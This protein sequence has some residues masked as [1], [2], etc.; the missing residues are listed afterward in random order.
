MAVLQK[1]VELGRY[2][3][4]MRLI[5]LKTP[6]KNI[7][8][9]LRNPCESVIKAITGPLKTYILSELNA[10]DLIIVAKE[11]E[12]EWVTLSLTPNFKLLGKK[13][14]KKMKTV[15]SA[16]QKMTH[17]EAVACLEK[18][19]LEIEG[20]IICAKTEITSKLSFSKE[21]EQWE[22]ASTPGGDCVIAID[23]TQDEAILSAGRARE[24]INHIQQLRKNAGLDMKDKVEAFFEENETTSVTENAVSMNVDVFR[25]KFKGYVPLPKRFAPKWSVVIGSESVEIAGSKVE[26]SIC[27]PAVAAKDGLSDAQNTFISTIEPAS[28]KPGDEISFSVDGKDM[29]V[30]EGVD[31]WST[32]LAKVEAT[33]AVSWL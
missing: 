21:G 3:R 14:G 31:F 26:V 11:D 25:S 13:F 1:I 17:A 7:A 10:W 28:V 6:V 23:C 33:E 32:T 29:K 18:G 8:V 12:H 22:S 19:S 20:G 4:E 5:N 24:L 30:K 2:A 27:R 15:A 16:I 9:V